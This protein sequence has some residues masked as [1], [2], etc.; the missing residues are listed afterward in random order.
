MFESAET[1][2]RRIRERELSSEA[3]VELYLSRINDINPH[4]NA[5]VALADDAIDLARASDQRLSAGQLEP[6][7]HGRIMLRNELLATQRSPSGD[8]ASRVEAILDGHWHAMQR[9]V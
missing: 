9:P 6:L 7:H 5:V 2:A 4:I 8:D 3:L 1:L